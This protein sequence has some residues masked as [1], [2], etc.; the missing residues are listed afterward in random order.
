M[1]KKYWFLLAALIV[2]FG[3]YFT[4][5]D[6]GIAH[7][8]NEVVGKYVPGDT[9]TNYLSALSTYRGEG[10]YKGFSIVYPPGRF[11]ALST[12]FYFLGASLP[13]FGFYF[14][15]FAPLL[16]PTFL[17]I[18]SFLILKRFISEKIAFLLS[19][20]PLFF[21]MTIVRSAQEVHVCIALFFIVSL[22]KFKREKIQRL[23]LGIALGLVFLFRIESGILLTT[24]L[25]LTS[26]QL[27]K[28]KEFVR[29]III[30]FAL[31]WVP[32]LLLVVFQGSIGNFFNDL[33]ILGFIIHP[34]IGEEAISP[35]HIRLFIALGIYLVASAVALFQNTTNKSLKSFA[36][37][38]ALSFISS[39]GRSDEGHLWYGLMWISIYVGLACIFV[40]QC[41]LPKKNRVFVDALYALAIAFLVGLAVYIKITI[42][43]LLLVLVLFV[44]STYVFSPK[45]KSLV[46]VIGALVSLAIFHSASYLKLRFSPLTLK[47]DPVHYAPDFFH[48]D[49]DEI[50]G[51]IFPKDEM[52]VLQKIAQHI[53]T[54]EHY[55]F[56]FPDYEILYEYFDQHNPTRYYNLSGERTDSTEREVIKELENKNV[57][58]FLV[59]PQRAEDRGGMVWDWIMNHTKMY[60]EYEFSGEPV[61]LRK[62][63]E[64]LSIKGA[65]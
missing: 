18:L 11:L 40:V 64:P 19:F 24:A 57:S 48:D 42:L 60:Q 53:P 41:K 4:V 61:E 33:F 49:D 54:N 29:Q 16:F 23:L 32:V 27:M 17:F 63:K 28:K 36:I 10:L 26:Y 45:N 31:V 30:G 25:V 56:I 9:E 13:T 59:F 15:F 58:Y 12:L 5:V 55:I 2:L 39:L 51:M 62:I 34:R 38:S 47:F 21:D 37:F 1:I 50:A 20:V 35:D 43:F 22:L 6:G 52:M 14:N 7:L 8:G 65:I 3:V 44:F 46:F